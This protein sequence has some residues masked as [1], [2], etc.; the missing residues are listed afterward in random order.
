ML[1]T[2]SRRK[3]KKPNTKDGLN[4]FEMT[5]EKLFKQI[6]EKKK[7]NAQYGL[8][9]SSK[10]LNSTNKNQKVEKRPSQLT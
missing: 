3:N 9:T 7:N 2:T 5:N 6:S 10:I 4:L 8:N 1:S